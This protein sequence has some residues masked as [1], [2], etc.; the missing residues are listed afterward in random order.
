MRNVIFQVQNFS[1]AN[2]V[3]FDKIKKLAEH[4]LAAQGSG[5]EVFV[6]HDI[7]TGGSNT[8]QMAY[9]VSVLN[10]VKVML[11][12]AEYETIGQLSH[13]AILLMRCLHQQAQI[14]DEDRHLDNE[15]NRST[16]KLKLKILNLA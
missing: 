5:R 16:I 1:E 3:S 2:N 8:D 14:E 15:A 11:H 6:E 9:V 7:P 13:L 10:V 4:V 12:A